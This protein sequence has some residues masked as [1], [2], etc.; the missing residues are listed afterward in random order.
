MWHSVAQSFVKGA[1]DEVQGWTVNPVSSFAMSVPSIIACNIAAAAAGATSGAYDGRSIA[2]ATIAGLAIRPLQSG[3]LETPFR[4]GLQERWIRGTLF[5][6][7]AFT[8]AAGGLAG[9]LSA[10]ASPSRIQQ[11]A[12]STDKLTR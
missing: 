1:K 2:F 8:M 12:Q 4:P 5:T 11:R 9:Q 10:D 6:C 7:A 3:I